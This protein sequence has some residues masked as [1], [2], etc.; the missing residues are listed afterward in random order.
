LSATSLTF[1]ATGTVRTRIARVGVLAIFLPL[2]ACELVFPNVVV[3]EADGGDAAAG[4]AAGPWCQTQAHAFCSDFD[5]TSVERGWDSLGMSDSGATVV[6]DDGG[7]TSP[8]YSMLGATP[9]VPAGVYPVAGVTKSLHFDP[10]GVRISFDVRIEEMDEMYDGSFRFHQIEVDA[11]P[12]VGTYY[13]HLSQ[14][15]EG[16]YLADDRYFADGGIEHTEYPIPTSL[17]VGTWVRVTI[18]LGEPSATSGA[19]SVKYD[20]VSVLDGATV[21]PY[22]PTKPRSVFLGP[23]LRGGPSGPWQVRYD[24]Y[25]VDS[26]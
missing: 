24:N 15:K 1:L 19:A 14:H 11:V 17:P 10:N 2:I 13:V 7:W 5:G 9:T 16:T 23:D 18:E 25:T 22:D 20:G 4:G 8:P 12:E 3:D 26:P 21:F 6:Q